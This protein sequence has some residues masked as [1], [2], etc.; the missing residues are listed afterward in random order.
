[1][2]S[3]AYYAGTSFYLTTCIITSLRLFH[4]SRWCSNSAVQFCCDLVSKHF[5]SM[6]SS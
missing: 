4:D 5:G 2:S 3:L 1:V 6:Y